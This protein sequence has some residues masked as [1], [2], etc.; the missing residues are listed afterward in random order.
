MNLKNK[1]IKFL[2]AGVLNTVLS[3]FL[4]AA[5]VLFLSYQVSY[6]LSFIFGILV[7][8]VLNTKYVFETKQT[9]KKFTLFPLVYVMQYLCGALLMELIVDVFGIT[10]FIAPLIVT[11]CLLPI[12]YILSKKIL[13]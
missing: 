2:G 5:L 10:K 1:F 7:S 3:Y 12:S 13:L 4:Y 8:F 11:I 6:A 9:M